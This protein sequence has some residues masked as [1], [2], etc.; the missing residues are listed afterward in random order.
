MLN[1]TQIKE[2]T[3]N[4]LSLYS[5]SFRGISGAQIVFR[6]EFFLTAYPHFFVINNQYEKNCSI[7]VLLVLI[8]L[9]ETSWRT[10]RGMYGNKKDSISHFCCERLFPSNTC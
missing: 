2:I 8:G 1:S 10:N 7:S 4:V 5:R 6:I 3:I 9:Q